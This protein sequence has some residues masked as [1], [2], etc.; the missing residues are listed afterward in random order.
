VEPDQPLHR[1]EQI[2]RHAPAEAEEDDRGCEIR[3][4]CPPGGTLLFSGAQLHS[5]VTNSSGRTRYSIDFRT[6]HR[7]EAERGA[8]A[9]NIDSSCTGT[10]LG[11]FLRCSDL[12]HLPEPLIEAHDRGFGRASGEAR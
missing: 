7:A 9:P 1:G 8:G 6:V 12:A 5:S 11:D 2:G 4:L 10:A 3:P